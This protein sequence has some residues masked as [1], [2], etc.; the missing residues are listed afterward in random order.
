MNLKVIG[1]LLGVIQILVA[2]WYFDWHNWTYIFVSTLLFLSA[3]NGFLTDSKS[4]LQIKIKK[5][6]RAIGFTVVIIL[7][8]RLI[9]VEK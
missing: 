8:I 1:I 2:I 4:D 6:I 3:I 9:F 7:F 5:F